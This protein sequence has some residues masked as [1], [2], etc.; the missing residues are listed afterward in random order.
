MSKDLVRSMSSD[1]V[2]PNQPSRTGRPMDRRRKVELF[3]EI[4]REHGCGTGQFGQ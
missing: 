2:P 4:R 1:L 3:E